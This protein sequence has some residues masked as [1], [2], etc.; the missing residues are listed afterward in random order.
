MMTISNIP[1]YGITPQPLER[2]RSSAWEGFTG[3]L[4]GYGSGMALATGAV[5]AAERFKSPEA[6]IFH[7]AV[8]SNFKGQGFKADVGNLFQKIEGQNFLT[9]TEA[10]TGKLGTQLASFNEALGNNSRVKAIILGTATALGLF[11]LAKG[12]IGADNHNR[13]VVDRLHAE[14]SILATK[15]PPMETI[16]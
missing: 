2:P 12:V 16:F 3:Q 11:G 8:K 7:N 5:V 6:R 13:N 15:M 9:K 14:N 10:L 1:G 4:G